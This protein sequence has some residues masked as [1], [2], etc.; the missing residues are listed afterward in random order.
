MTPTLEEIL[1]A[2]S[3]ETG[4]DTETIKGKNK[5]KPVTL[6][7][8]VFC[9][10]SRSETL[11]SYDEIAE[12]IG[13]THAAALYA[14]EKL[15]ET[16]F[17]TEREKNTINGVQKLLREPVVEMTYLQTALLGKAYN[18]ANNHTFNWAIRALK[19]S[20]IN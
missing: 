9:F 7:R 6:A 2:V 10:V 8:Q 5:K 1:N 4:I 14:Y 12:H 3:V 17:L 15:R 13:K 16:G 20:G 18:Y 11:C 19:E